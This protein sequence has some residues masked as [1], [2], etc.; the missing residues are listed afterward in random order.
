M[1][2]FRSSCVDVAFPVV[3]CRLYNAKTGISGFCGAC[4]SDW[5]SCLFLAAELLVR[6]IALIAGFCWVSLRC[7]IFASGVFVL[8]WCGVVIGYT[9]PHRVA[10]LSWFLVLLQALLERLGRCCLPWIPR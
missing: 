1:C 2:T 6:I 7:C 4:V 5:I 10:L 8:V 3:A 9:M